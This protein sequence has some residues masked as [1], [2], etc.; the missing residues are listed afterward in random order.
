MNLTLIAAAAAIPPFSPNLIADV[1]EMLG[2][3]FM[4]YAVLAGSASAVVAGLVGYFVVLRGLAFASDALSDFAFPAALGALL[5]GVDVRI[6]LIGIT[7]LVA[8][9]IGAL[10]ERVRGRDVAVGTVYTW[11]IGLG[12]LF[13][14]LYS[15]TRRGRNGNAGVSILFGSILGLNRGQAI[16][17]ACIAGGVIAVLLCIVRPLLLASFL[18]EVAA[19]RGVPVRMLNIMF[20]VLVAITVANAVPTIGSLLVF[21]LLVTPAAVAHRL[22]ARPG[23]GI[24]LAAGIALA[25]VWIG[26]FVGFY[27]PYPVSSLI[28]TVAFVTYVSVVVVRPL[29]IRRATL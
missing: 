13:L 14:A 21:A 26:L 6:G 16:L 27:T 18:P 12:V 19:A 1:R 5:L 3:D 7:V 22:T 9:G 10:G 24:A 20:L 25:F 8:I 29:R 4:R 17:A 28:T 23:V 15:A 11:V 2:Y